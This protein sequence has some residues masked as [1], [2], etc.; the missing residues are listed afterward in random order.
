MRLQGL[1]LQAEEQ[2][3]IPLRQVGEEEGGK[4][5][6][7]APNAVISIHPS[8]C[9]GALQCALPHDV[10]L[11]A[12]SPRLARAAWGTMPLQPTEAA[13][14]CTPPCCVCRSLEDKAREH[15]ITDLADF[16]SSNV[17]TSSGFELHANSNHIVYSS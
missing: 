8:I 7:N 10:P 11:V 1:V 3:K 12:L 15:E 4:K 16:Y 9:P 13:R 17:F 6:Y 14:F 2:Y 5:S